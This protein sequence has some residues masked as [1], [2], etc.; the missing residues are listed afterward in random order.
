MATVLKATRDLKTGFS[1]E[2]EDG[3]PNAL[4]SMR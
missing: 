2:H 1:S 4:L 3:G